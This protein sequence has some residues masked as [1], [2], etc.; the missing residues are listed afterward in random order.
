MFLHLTEVVDY[1]VDLETTGIDVLND[2]AIQLSVLD[3]KTTNILC[4]EHL[5]SPV[6]ISKGAFRIHGK[7]EA[8]LLEN[9]A[10]EFMGVYA[11]IASLLKEKVVAGYNVAFDACILDNMCTRRGLEP[12]KV[13]MWVDL[14]P[15]MTLIH[16]RWSSY[17]KGFAWPKLSDFNIRKRELHDAV[18][19]CLVL[20]DY[21]YH[22][23]NKIGGK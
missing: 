6:P 23:K 7:D 17:R 15:A 8:W 18:S 11:E 5:L 20:C 4:N 19:D 12:F 2:E 16:G 21:I 3:L 22:I 13:G 10:V 9:D 14:M 1:V